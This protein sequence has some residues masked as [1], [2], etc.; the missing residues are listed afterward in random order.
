M[1][2]ASALMRYSTLSFLIVVITLGS[3]CA[4][5]AK[6][7]ESPDDALKRNER[8]SYHDRNGD[9]KVDEEMHK[10]DG[11]ADADWTLRDDDYDGR[12]EKK[13]HWG[14]A[15]FELAVD[16]PVPTGVRIEAKK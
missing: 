12:F 3:G 14:F 8:I 10:Y 1:S 6:P 7:N 16:L 9:G 13:I 4:H 5:S 11:F 15:L 2:Q